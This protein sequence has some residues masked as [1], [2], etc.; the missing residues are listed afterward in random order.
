MSY[1]TKAKKK[2][3]PKNDSIKDWD[4]E[5]LVSFDGVYSQGMS[6]HQARSAELRQ[7]VRKRL[8]ELRGVD[9]NSIPYPRSNIDLTEYEKE[10]QYLEGKL[11]FCQANSA[12]QVHYPH[13][14]IL[15]H[16]NLE[17]KSHQARSAELRQQVRNRLAELKNVDPSSIPYPR[18]N[19]K[20]TEYENEIQYLEE[21]S[22]QARSAELRQQVRNRLAEL[23]G[24]DPNSI[25][26]P[27]SNIKLTEYENK[28]LR[29]EIEERGCQ[30][31]LQ[32]EKLEKK[33]KEL[34]DQEKNS[35]NNLKKYSIVD[36]RAYR[37]SDDNKEQ[38][39]NIIDNLGTVGSDNNKIKLSRRIPAKFDAIVDISYREDKEGKSAFWDHYT[40]QRITHY[41]TRV[42]GTTNDAKLLK[43][44]IYD[45]TYGLPI[46]PTDSYNFKPTPPILKLYPYPSNDLHGLLLIP[47]SHS[48]ISECPNY[49]VR[50]RNEEKLINDAWNRGRPV[51]G[52]CD[53]ALEI[54]KLFGG[55]EVKVHHHSW[56]M[57]PYLT[58]NG[59]VGHNVTMHGLR[60][61][62][63][64][65][66]A[67]A[68]YGKTINKNS[69]FVTPPV[70]NSVHTTAMCSSIIPSN[71]K[72]V[73]RSSQC[74]KKPINREPEDNVTEAVETCYGAPMLL[75]QWHPEAFNSDDRDGKYHQNILIYMAKA[76]DTYY[77]KQKMHLE[78]KNEFRLENK[79]SRLSSFNI[80]KSDIPSLEQ[81]INEYD[82]KS[83]M[84]S[85]KQKINDKT[86]IPSLKQ[87][88]SENDNKSDMLNLKQKLTN[89][90]KK[91][92]ST[93]EEQAEHQT[94]SQFSLN[95]A[96]NFVPVFS[97]VYSYY[98]TSK[99]NEIAK[100]NDAEKTKQ[101]NS[102]FRKAHS[103]KWDE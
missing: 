15:E 26:Y 81:K 9:P 17:E 94:S 67:D 50:K 29:L 88:I 20:L 99:M 61:H 83:D 62:S 76:G 66:L 41:P 42:V 49:E 51:L 68:M 44:V 28:I 79:F 33:L 45:I 84:P 55:K 12:K 3:L 57:M 13:S 90:G 40:F 95:Q 36:N 35:F 100:K 10:I 91:Y 19:I 18:S 74:D 46:S 75:I 78:L 38:N 80:L 52:I 97:H 72:I 98:D 21:N 6:S 8:A 54:W 63:S 58:K 30:E 73:A 23:K 16:I 102:T 1:S 37:F 56:E 64:S 2:R 86:D 48:N 92:Q 53:G 4:T 70:T 101:I 65:M 93:T 69:T 77:W 14:G 7:R 60:I 22:H 27:R 11:L 82:N 103:G 89:E 96:V 85:Y 32:L 5:T 87:K 34:E 43:D 24:V 47:G 71:M 31:R 59:R 25:P 39:Q